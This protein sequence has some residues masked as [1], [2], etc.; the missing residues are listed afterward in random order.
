MPYIAPSHRR[1]LDQAIDQLAQALVAEAHGLKEEA[2]IAGLLNYALTRLSLQVVYRRHG[3]LRYWLIA[4]V[5]GVLHNVA[6]EFY[7]RLAAVYEDKQM[8]RQGDVDLYAAFLREM[9]E[10]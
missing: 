4:L 6:A 10:A 7:R 3:R 9:E 1:N 8:A 5:T 2:A